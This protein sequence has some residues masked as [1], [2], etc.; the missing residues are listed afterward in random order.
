MFDFTI[1]RDLRAIAILDE[2]VSVRNEL[3]TVYCKKNS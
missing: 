2:A 1:I 3:I